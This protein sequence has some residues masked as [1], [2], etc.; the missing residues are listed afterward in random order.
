[1]I[2]TR[3][4]FIEAGSLW[5]DG[6][7]GSPPA[8]DG[9][10]GKRLLYRIHRAGGAENRVRYANIMFE[11]EHYAGRGGLGAVLGAKRVKAV[12]VRG[13]LRSRV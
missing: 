4:V 12:A 7:G 2:I 11:P 10:H 5:G 9:G 1:M 6:P 3:Y 13:A 8:D